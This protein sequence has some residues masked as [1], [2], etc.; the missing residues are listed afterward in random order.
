M[1]AV[2]LTLTRADVK[3]ILTLG[4]LTVSFG[5]MSYDDPERLLC[6]CTHRSLRE[7]E[8]VEYYLPRGPGKWEKVVFA[9]DCPLHGVDTNPVSDETEIIQPS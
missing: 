2:L 8:A 6:T 1:E 7:S 5:P 3:Q 9:R 4:W